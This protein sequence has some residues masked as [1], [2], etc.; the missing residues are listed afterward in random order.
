MTTT[1]SACTTVQPCSLRRRCFQR[2]SDEIGTD[3]TFC[4][5]GRPSLCIEAVA[6]CH[7]LSTLTPL[8]RVNPRPQ[9]SSAEAATPLFYI[10]SAFYVKCQ[11]RAR[12]YGSEPQRS[13]T[14]PSFHALWPVHLHER[15]TTEE[16]GFCPQKSLSWH[17]FLIV[18]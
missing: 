3:M 2:R 9:R 11:V 18:P 10:F 12:L 7:C 13:S 16:R 6:V 14:P 4:K 5:R 1:S 15:E 17:L 8:P